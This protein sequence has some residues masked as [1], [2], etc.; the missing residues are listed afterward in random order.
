MSRNLRIL[1]ITTFTLFGIISVFYLFR[2]QFSFD[3]EQ[4]FPTDDPDLE[5]FREFTESFE[6]DDNFMLIAA[7]REEG[8]FEQNFLQEFQRLSIE[9]K[10]LPYILESQSLTQ[11]S[12]PL[13]T[14]FGMTAIP[15]IHIDDP[16]KY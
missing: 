8:V 16:S 15:T 13:K 14:P 10:K 6:T 9:I 12:Y 7:Q 11:I 1:S 2:L 5:Y 3:F 4:F